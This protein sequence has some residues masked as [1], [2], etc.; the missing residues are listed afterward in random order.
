MLPRR[1]CRVLRDAAICQSVRPSVCPSHASRAKTAR[2]RHSFYETLIENPM[3]D[4]KSPVSVAL[5]QSR[6]AERP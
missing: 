6:V 3:L 1:M 2:F 5:R 4:V